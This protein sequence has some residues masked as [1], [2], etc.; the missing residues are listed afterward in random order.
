MPAAAFLAREA[1][2]PILDFALP[3][4]CPGCGAVTRDPH[5]F[6]LPCWS[7][8]AFL[9][10]PCCARCALPFDFG[11]G[12]K[13]ICGRCMAEP[14]PYDRLRAAVAYGEISRAVA[15]KLKYGGRPGVAETIARFMQRHLDPA[16]GPMLAPVPLH[17]WR[18]WRRGYNQ[19]ALIAGAL[20]RRAGLEARLDLV[21]RVKATPVLRGMSPRQRKEAVRG[22]FRVNPKRKAAVKGRAIILVDDVYTSGATANACA[23]IL[24]R[25]GAARVDMLCWARVVR[26]DLP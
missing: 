22:A 14:P 13:V 2:R 6:C 9:G 12:E 1:L 25:A 5:R 24:K 20:A 23:R 3:P 10:E 26:E 21:E 4:R 15:L 17:R 16:E 8:L 19:A 7:A 18:I 11:E